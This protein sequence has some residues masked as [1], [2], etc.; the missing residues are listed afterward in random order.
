MQAGGLADRRALQIPE[1][2]F[3]RLFKQRGNGF[4]RARL[5]EGVRLHRAGGKPTAIA[6]FPAP[7]MPISTTLVISRRSAR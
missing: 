7:G 6:L 1:R 4:P 5:H 2:P 3:P